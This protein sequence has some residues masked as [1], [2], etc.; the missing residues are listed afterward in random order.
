MTMNGRHDDHGGAPSGPHDPYG[1]APHDGVPAGPAGYPDGYGDAYEGHPAP[2]GH[3]TPGPAPGDYGTPAGSAPYESREGH[4]GPP[5]SEGW[6]GYPGQGYGTPAAPGGWPAQDP[7]GHG[8]QGGPYGYGSPAGGYGGREEGSYGAPHRGGPAG[9]GGHQDGS[10]GGSRQDGFHGGYGYGYEAPSHGTG[11]GAGAARD[12]A[13]YDHTI[14]PGGPAAAAY[15]PEPLGGL[16]PSE[17]EPGAGFGVPAA[18]D[19]WGGRGDAGVPAGA[20]H[21]FAAAPPAWEPAPPAAHPWEDQGAAGTAEPELERTA[22]MP[23]VAEGAPAAGTA[24]R[25]GSPI[26]PPG[27]QPAGLTAVLGLLL[28]GGAA[29]GR[30]LLAVAL[31]LLEAVTAAGWFRLNGMWPARQ[32]IA[33]A[34]MG[35]VAAEVAVL[36]VNGSHATAALLGVL[37]VWLLLVLVLQLRHHGSA[38]ERLASLTATSAATLLAV[39]AAGYLAAD[40][41]AGSDAVVV[42]TVAVAAATLVRAVRLMGPDLVSV[43]AS[44]GVAAVVGAVIGSATGFGGTDGLLLGAVAGLCALVG[45]RVASYDWPSRFV[46]FT[47]GVALP[48]TLAVPAVWALG[49]ALS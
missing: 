34:F 23:V 3:G 21:G 24:R 20:R 30:P 1:S 4:A 6:T 7:A 42:G 16:I 9:Y 25:T 5:A 37:G 31:M 19:A 11:P 33:L 13:G 43:A 39:V 36:S 38:D 10:Y 49:A 32:G 8:T 47:A 40:A 41:R 15:V 22:P 27:I 35:G 12:G 44:F 2:A 46:H 18:G 29:V 26:I 17:A 28:A 45:L 14:P 48:L